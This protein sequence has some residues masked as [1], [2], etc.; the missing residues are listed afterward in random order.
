MA[1]LS[2]S[3]DN[4]NGNGIGS[5]YGMH[6]LQWTSSFHHRDWHNMP[7]ADSVVALERVGALE[8]RLLRDAGKTGFPTQPGSDTPHYG[9]V[10]LIKNYGHLVGGSLAHGHQQIGFSN[11]MPR[12]VR[13]NWRFQKQRGESFAAH[14]LRETPDSLLVREYGPATLLVPYF[15]RRPYDMQLIL[16]DASRRYLYQLN[17]DELEAVA[18][19]WRDAIRLIRHVM[20]R[21]GRETAYNVVMNSGPGAGLYFEFLPYTQETGGFEQLGLWICQNSPT[22]AANTL[23][24]ALPALDE[25]QQSE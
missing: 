15:M 9:Y 21:I 7:V 5:A 23:R 18:R 1:V 3:N 11:V 19:G 10:S 22:N 25:E 16:K 6:F 4:G 20:P 14:M 24:G 17:D 12:K 13:N 2:R 8:K